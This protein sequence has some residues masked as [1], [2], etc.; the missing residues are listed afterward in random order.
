MSTTE[1]R[2]RAASALAAVAPGTPRLDAI[3]AQAKPLTDAQR[4]TIRA[5]FS[6][7]KSGGRR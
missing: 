4:A 2:R 1:S 7:R 6:G 3:I 5:A